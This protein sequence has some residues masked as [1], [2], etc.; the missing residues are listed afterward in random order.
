MTYLESAL[1]KVA[2]ELSY[3]EK[4]ALAAHFASI[5]EDGISSAPGDVWIS[6]SNSAVK[7]LESLESGEEKGFE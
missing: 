1:K 2:A 6:I 4:K 3:K 7:I 5:V